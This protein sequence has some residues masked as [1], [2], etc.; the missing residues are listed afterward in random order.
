MGPTASLDALKKEPSLLL[1]GIEK[2]T[3][4]CPR[5]SLVNIPYPHVAKVAT[6]N[7]MARRHKI[8][9]FLHQICGKN[10]SA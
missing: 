9:K 6:F 2:R 1:K 7:V 4:G 5:R 8:R 3:L 10:C